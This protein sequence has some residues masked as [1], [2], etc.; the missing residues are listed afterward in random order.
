[1]PGDVPGDDWAIPVLGNDFSFIGPVLDPDRAIIVYIGLADVFMCT[2]PRLQ[3]LHVNQFPE[4]GA[5][6]IS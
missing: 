3:G 5:L 1:M 4:P 2:Q 6:L